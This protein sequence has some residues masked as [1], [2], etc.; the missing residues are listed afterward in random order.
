VL[1]SRYVVLYCEKIKSHPQYHQADKAELAEISR[2][3]KTIAMPRAEK[4]KVHVK[5]LFAAEAAR[6]KA[7]APSL[8]DEAA[9]NN[10]V[11][12]SF[13]ED[14]EEL[15]R[16]YNTLNE[17]ELRELME[18]KRREAAGSSAASV[19]SPADPKAD[20]NK[21][22][23]DRSLKPQHRQNSYNLRTVNF[24]IFFGTS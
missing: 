19:S 3:I 9:N 20:G 1:Y 10:N 21:P 4:L 23:F 22:S 12:P 24:G 7:S 6:S 17:N 18:R 8:D 11:H 13:E 14:Y 2:Q 5:E 15:K 16:R